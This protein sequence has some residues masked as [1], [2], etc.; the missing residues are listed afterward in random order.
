MEDFIKEVISKFTDFLR[1][2]SSKLK[3]NRSSAPLV[4]F[5][6]KIQTIDLKN[7]IDYLIKYY[8][9]SFYFEK[10]EETFAIL[11]V[12][13]AISIS[14]NGEKRFSATDKKVKELKNNFINNWQDIPLKAKPLFVGG[15]KFNVEHSD[16]DW[17]DFN[18]STWYVPEL[19]VVKSKQDSYI[20]F[21]FINSSSATDEN[22][23]EKLKAKLE[24]L[25]KP[26]EAKSLSS[27]KINKLTGASPK[28]KKKWKCLVNSCLEDIFDN[29]VNK[30]V[31]SRRI[32]LLLSKE[33]NLDY[34]I[35]HFEQ[36]YPACYL[37]IFH[38]GKSSFIGATPERL[39]QFQDGKIKI[40]ALAGSAP[41]GENLE[42]DKALEKKLLASEKDIA[43]HDFVVN[44][45]KNS[46]TEI[47][48]NL[49]TEKHQ[50]K[51][52]KNIQ[53]ISTFISAEMNSHN[54]PLAII[55]ELFPTPAVCGMP[56]EISLN[57]IKKMESH[58]RGLYSG[59]IG[60]FNFYDEGE[61]AV[62]I[63]SALTFGNKLIA[64]AGSGIVEK[65]DPDTEYEETELKLKPILSLF[66]E[67]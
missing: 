5:V 27:I 4:S 12:D 19:I 43:E 1:Q 64:F 16:E 23:I 67:N 48:E 31:L 17:K 50:I 10:P 29:K 39:A 53:H 32:D 46:I 60:W 3:D 14:E 42:E 18:D 13:E 28:D 52:L 8:E 44:H 9:K 40:E 59:V 36:K 41:R 63:R 61:F 45:I 51:K 66:N 55:K 54:S 49:N 30:I 57:L 58:N 7:K 47:V 62:A 37:F 56:K 20:F 35:N 25:I 15:M 24:N 33:L 65:S 38:K 34:A 26:A 6:S 2:N 22:L 11:G 21:N